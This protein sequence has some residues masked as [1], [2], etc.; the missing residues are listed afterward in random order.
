LLALVGK[1]AAAACFVFALGE[2]F[3]ERAVLRDDAE[4]GSLRA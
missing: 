2:G 3:D 4:A 1:D